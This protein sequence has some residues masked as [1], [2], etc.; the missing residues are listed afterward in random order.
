MP[1]NF[2]Q[3]NDQ[4]IVANH[5]NKFRDEMNSL[6]PENWEL[7]PDL[8]DVA[9]ISGDSIGSSYLKISKSPMIAGG[10][11][12]LVSK[13]AFNLPLRSAFGITMSQRIVG[14]EHTVGI[15]GVTGYGQEEVVS[16]FTP[17]LISGTIVVA[18]NVWTINTAT[19][20]GLKQNDRII[21]YGCDD[22][23]LNV[24]PILITSITSP[25][26]FTITS[27]LA[28]ATYTVGA[29]GFI[30]K[31]NPTGLSKNAS[32]FLWDQAT[33]TSAM[34]YTRGGGGAPLQS[35]AT[36]FKTTVA[37][38]ATPAAFSDQFTSASAFEMWTG[39]DECAYRSYTVDANT[40]PV[41]TKRQQSLPDSEK[42]YKLKLRSKNLENMTAPVARITAI[43][44]AGSTTATVTTDVNHNLSVNSWVQILGVRDQT[45]FANTTAI[46]QVASIV[47]PTQF[48]IV[49]GAS[50]TASSLGGIVVLTHGSQVLVSPNFAVQSISRT[51]YLMTVTLNTTA[52]GF[53]VGETF[54]LY[55]LEPAALAYEGIYKVL[56]VT[57]ATVI[58]DS[59][60]VD[61]GSITTGGFL[62]K[63]TDIRV[64]F[65]RA[66]DHTRH[67]VEVYGGLGRADDANNAVQVNGVINS[68]TITTVST[69]TTVA[70]VT[71]ANLAIPGTIA[72]VA[73]AAI[74]TTTTTSAITPTFGT[75]YKIQIPVTAFSGTSPTLDVS[76]EE[77]A[78]TG[79]NWFKVYDFPRITTTGSY[80]SPTLPLVGNRIRYVQ[81][82]TG[83]TPSFT[84]A[85]NR[86]QSSW[87]NA[88]RIRQ[89]ID[90]TVVLTTLNS[91]TPVID[92]AGTINAQL[93]IALGAATTPPAIQL[94][95]SDDNT[96]F[97]SIGSPL[98][99]VASSAVQLTVNN[100][101]TKFLR[102]RVST[103]GATVTANYIL[104]KGF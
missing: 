84:R 81:T 53:L 35:A 7:T 68:G 3:V 36:T 82:V 20:H 47:S 103:A 8:N 88:E 33:T 55:G 72:D 34:T 19:N 62:I 74:T 100:I 79:T 101:Q 54:N 90:R 59:V 32:G 28:S 17:V 1:K 78:D 75:S 31:Y 98:T 45:N 66:A 104:I 14:Q 9:L 85:I 94:E 26:Q 51:S 41:L 95:G 76:I 60:G 22:S 11:T 93:V 63:R 44:K 38:P 13:E 24:G 21:L 18:T 39:F 96:N 12:S 83:T 23:R 64:H 49:F 69:V 46:T 92:V 71:S 16:D 48:T 87:T 52:S 97:Y 65:V 43:S 27:T 58:L 10:E 102:A 50:A 73:S 77:S 25:T 40:A 4:K 67:A 37:L 89:L 42:Q 5:I 6:A 80:T 15:V 99:G 57:G 56:N 30:K 70:A 2:D 91:T 61:F 29:V 86:L